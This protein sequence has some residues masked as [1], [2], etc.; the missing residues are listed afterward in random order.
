MKLARSV[1]CAAAGV[2]FFGVL[3]LYVMSCWWRINWEGAWDW[4]V[5]IRGGLASVSV[6]RLDGAGFRGPYGRGWLI[7]ADD[8]E[9]EFASFYS[10]DFGP[11]VWYSWG[12][13][14]AGY[15]AGL[16]DARR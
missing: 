1:V 11:F 4:E 15:A 8:S 12:M 6:P 2:M 16:A 13:C 9:L 3:V 14:S 5:E 7:E 10:A